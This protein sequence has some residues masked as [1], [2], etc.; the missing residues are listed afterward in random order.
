[1]SAKAGL[2]PA[3]SDPVKATLKQGVHEITV[4][5]TGENNELR[6]KYPD[7]WERDHQATT[8]QELA[9]KIVNNLRARYGVESVTI[10]K[11]PDGLTVSAT[12]A[13]EI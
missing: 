13:V 11:I 7:G 1:M 4:V 3:G 2:L 10:N 12:F 5:K 6:V 8:P 9:P